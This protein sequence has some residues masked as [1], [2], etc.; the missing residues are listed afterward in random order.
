M[1]STACAIR[2]QDILLTCSILQKSRKKKVLEGGEIDALDDSSQTSDS[3]V[4]VMDPKTGEVFCA[5]AI[6]HIR[7]HNPKL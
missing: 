2:C 6:F 5:F 1:L 7:F 4:S 3:R